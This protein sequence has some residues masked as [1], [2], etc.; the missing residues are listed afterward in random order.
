MKRQTTNMSQSEMMVSS[1]GDGDDEGMFEE[2]VE[3]DDVKEELSSDNDDFDYITPTPT[4]GTPTP[5][6]PNFKMKD[7]LRNQEK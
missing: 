7:A 2:E 1:E 3:L 6:N 4:G 5:S